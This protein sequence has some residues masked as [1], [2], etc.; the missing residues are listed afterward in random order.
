MKGNIRRNNPHMA[1]EFKGET[2]DVVEGITKDTK[3]AMMENISQYQQI[4]L[5]IQ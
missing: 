3:A 1:E 2:T 5:D 4:I